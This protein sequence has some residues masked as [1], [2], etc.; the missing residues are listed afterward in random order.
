M[1]LLAASTPVVDWGAL[2]KVVLY[3]VVA[4]VGV[5]VCVS[6]SILGATR[7]A[8]VRR[9]GSGGVGALAYAM[10]TLLGLAATL[11]SAVLAIV[12]MT[13]KS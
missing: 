1:S 7:F 3:S 2:G 5:A 10:L 11:G 13:R 6:L 4:G 9:G 12:V 8:E